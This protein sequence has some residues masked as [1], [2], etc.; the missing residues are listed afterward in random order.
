MKFELLESKT[1]FKGKVFNL[2]QDQVRMPDGKRTQLDIID[3]PPAVTLVPV[4]AEDYIW[5][6][7]QY[8][9]PTGGEILELP[10]G[11]METDE[12]P[13]VCASREIREE[14]GMSAGG[15]RLIGEFY[16]VPGYSSEYMYVYLAWDLKPEPLQG[17]ED[18][19]IS[20][21]RIPIKQ[22]YHMAENGEIKDAK[23]LAALLLAAPHLRN[24]VYADQG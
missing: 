16:E 22:A 12:A 4:D 19:F 11:V 24:K 23:T 2:R 7:R 6:V 15:M 3:H 20:V 13:E 9:H 14:I 5:F 17:D 1:I 8:R 10:A 18:E 21:E